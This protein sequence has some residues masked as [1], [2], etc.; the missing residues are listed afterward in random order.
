M[1]RARQSSLVLWIFEAAWPSFFDICRNFDQ[2]DLQRF[3]TRRRQPRAARCDCFKD[4]ARTQLAKPRSRHSRFATVIDRLQD[5]GRI[6]ITAPVDPSTGIMLSSWA[7]VKLHELDF[8]IGLGKPL[9]VRRPR[10]FQSRA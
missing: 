2:H 8:N 4:A 1:Q 9:A 3:F 7:S 6:S 5:K 10:S